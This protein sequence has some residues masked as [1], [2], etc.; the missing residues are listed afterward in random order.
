[1]SVVSDSD[2]SQLEKCCKG[3]WLYSGV[4]TQKMLI[5]WDCWCT[6]EAETGGTRVSLRS[7]YSIYSKFQGSQGYKVRVSEEEKE[8]KMVLRNCCPMKDSLSHTQT[9]FLQKQ[10]GQA[11]GM[12]KWLSTWIRELAHDLG[13]N[14]CYKMWGH[15]EGKG[16]VESSSIVLKL[17]W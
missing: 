5:C 9:R 6:R 14:L 8:E 13:Q 12:Q 15:F 11:S 2:M 4:S 17:L 7:A 10:S 3:Y 1:M 16:L